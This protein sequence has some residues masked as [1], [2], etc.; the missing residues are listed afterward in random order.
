MDGKCLYNIV[1]I[2]YRPV[3]K[4]HSRF[5]SSEVQRYCLID[6]YLMSRREQVFKYKTCDEK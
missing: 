5:S 3:E 1:D 2:S 6:Y 4:N